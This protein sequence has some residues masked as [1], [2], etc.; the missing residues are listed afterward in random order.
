MYSSDHILWRGDAAS[1]FSQDLGGNGD[2]SLDVRRSTGARDSGRPTGGS[3]SGRVGVMTA[4][5]TSEWKKG[6]DG[7][8]EKGGKERRRM[9]AG[10]SS[11]H[12]AR[13]LLVDGQ[14]GTLSL[15]LPPRSPSPS[16]P[17]WPSDDV[18]K[19]GKKTSRR[20]SS[21]D[22]EIR[23]DGVGPD[24]GTNSRRKRR[25]ADRRRGGK[26]ERQEDGG[27]MGEA[28]GGERGAKRAGAGE[29][30]GGRL[31]RERE[32]SVDGGGSLLELRD[33]L[34]SREKDLLRLKRDVGAVATSAG[35]FKHL[36][37]SLGS[38]VNA[39]SSAGFGC[40]D[41]ND[42]D[43]D[44]TNEDNRPRAPKS[45]VTK[46]RTG[47]A[48]GGGN[49]VDD[50]GEAP[51]RVKDA[52]RRSYRKGEIGG[53]SKSSWLPAAT[54]VHREAPSARATDLLQD[55]VY[56]IAQSLSP[57]PPQQLLSTSKGADVAVGGSRLVASA[58]GALKRMRAVLEQREVAARR[59]KDDAGKMVGLFTVAVH[60]SHG[61]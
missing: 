3:A 44:G 30:R 10:V 55:G 46:P 26:G 37:A 42:D 56:A 18:S 60:L 33:A 51:L 19:G 25:P 17:P 58:H 36:A 43:N 50:A 28:E 9:S 7:E 32:D 61:E 8:E 52:T 40:Y 39:G 1:G 31:E 49:A 13:A 45:R 22:E 53:P 2:D 11:E 29:G 16:P 57:P 14:A 23:D 20:H 41:D 34:K 12:R 21:E 54:A 48:L 27:G 5:V 24:R 38:G 35:S 6:D 4:T 47:P 59:A 15:P